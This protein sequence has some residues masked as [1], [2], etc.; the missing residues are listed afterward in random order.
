[1]VEGAMS[2]ARRYEG[3]DLGMGVGMVLGMGMGMGMGMA[4]RGWDGMACLHDE[5]RAEDW[6]VELI[7]FCVGIGN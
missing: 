1:M 4:W 2:E 3:G 7:C 6:T 5:G